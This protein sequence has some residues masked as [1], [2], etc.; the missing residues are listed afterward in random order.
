[1][2]GSASTRAD[3]P[4]RRGE[5]QALQANSGSRKKCNGVGRGVLAES[6]IIV[7]LGDQQWA[8]VSLG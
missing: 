8:V 4:G 6:A 2:S 5:L 7:L 1:M 3:F